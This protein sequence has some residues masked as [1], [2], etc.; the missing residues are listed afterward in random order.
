MTTRQQRFN[1]RQAPTDLDEPPPSKLAPILQFDIVRL[2][3]HGEP[4]WPPKYFGNKFGPSF[5]RKVIKS[6]LYVMAEV[7][8]FPRAVVISDA[9]W[10]DGMLVVQTAEG[11]VE[12]ERLYTLTSL[13]GFKL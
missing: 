1:S 3:K 12:P 9:S 10:C 4:P 11:L 2:N 7:N 6:G 8:G 13:K 5:I